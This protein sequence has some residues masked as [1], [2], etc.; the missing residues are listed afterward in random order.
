M[1]KQA[2]DWVEAIKVGLAAILDTLTAGKFTE[3]IGKMI[4]EPSKF[5]E[6]RL[7]DLK[8]LGSGLMNLIK[9]GD[10]S[11]TAPPPSGSVNNVTINVD[12]SKDP[13]AVGNEVIQKLKKA[14]G[15]SYFQQPQAGY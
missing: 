3:G 13:K 7:G 14:T 11:G 10:P 1:F 2:A 6:D 15:D 12:G 9:T 8:S 4:F 5:A